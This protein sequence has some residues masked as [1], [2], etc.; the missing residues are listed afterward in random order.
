MLS[1]VPKTS[2][3]INR[4]T[5]TVWHQPKVTVLDYFGIWKIVT[6][7]P[8]QGISSSTSRHRIL[9]TCRQEWRDTHYTIW[10][11]LESPMSSSYN[12]D[13]GDNQSSPNFSQY[14][15]AIPSDH[16]VAFS[17]VGASFH[18]LHVRVPFLCV[19]WGSLTLPD[20]RG[21]I[22]D[23]CRTHKVYF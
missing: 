12:S 18:S 2:W 9:T 14:S 21:A 15:L 5:H 16:W 8:G 23:R 4:R 7:Y 1:G 17:H 10:T 3:F 6:L 13:N 22:L 19:R 11:L 20:A